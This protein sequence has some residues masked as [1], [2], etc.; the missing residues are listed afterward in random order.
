MVLGSQTRLSL[1]NV[2][3]ATDFSSR[4]EVAMPYSIGMSRRYGATLYTVTVVS[5]EI[6]YDVQPPDPFYLRHSAEKKMEK[7]VSSGV[8]A[9]IKHIE[10][11][12]EGFDSVLEVLLESIV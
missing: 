11:V 8:F 4:S 1:R 12:K 6:T 2:L 5:S 9:G 7:I 3:F 10:L